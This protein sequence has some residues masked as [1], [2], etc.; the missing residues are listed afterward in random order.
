M[1]TATTTNCLLWVCTHNEYYKNFIVKV[2]IV[3][4]WKLLI[5][6]LSISSFYDVL[7]TSTF[8]RIPSIGVWKFDVVVN[9]STY[10]SMGPYFPY[11]ETFGTDS[12]ICLWHRISR[13]PLNV[14]VHLYMASYLPKVCLCI[15]LWHNISRKSLPG[16]VCMASYLRTG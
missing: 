3:F 4:I 8:S 13:M 15:C 7:I 10:L 2:F 14:Y 6:L 11:L 5:I 16:R 1:K 9:L 12:M